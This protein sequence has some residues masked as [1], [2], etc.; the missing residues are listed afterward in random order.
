MVQRH[1]AR[2]LHYDFR[3]ERHGALASWAVPKGVPLEPGEKALAVH[4]EDHPLGYARSTARSRRASTARAVVEIWDNGTYELL[5]EKA[6]G[7]LTVALQREAAAGNVDARACAPGR[8]GAELAPGE[9]RRR[10]PRGARPPRPHLQPDAR[11]RA[12]GI[13][14][15]DDWVFEVKF[16]GFRTLAYIRNGECRLALAERERPDGAVCR[17]R[18]GGRQGDEEPER[19]S[20]RRDLPPRPVR[21][22]E[23]LGAAAGR[24]AAGALRLRPARARRRAARRPAADRAQAA[25]CGSCSTPAT[26]RCASRTTSTTARRCS[27]RPRER[28][29]EGVVAKRASSRY[30]RASGRATG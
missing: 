8:Q 25:G 24:R 11:N 23:L 18:Q 16:D 20:R 22:L 10:A 15:G 7:Q 28:G 19:R 12:R 2:R 14:T 17:D 13:P 5:E 30:A 29:L 1:D 6:N 27:P 9:G 3:L 4:V 21:T 26:A